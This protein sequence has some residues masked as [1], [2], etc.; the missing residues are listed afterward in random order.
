MPARGFLKNKKSRI[1]I[2]GFFVVCISLKRLKIQS[3]SVSIFLMLTLYSERMS[4]QK[5]YPREEFDDDLLTVL[6]QGKAVGILQGINVLLIAPENLQPHHHVITAT[7][8]A[9]RLNLKHRPEPRGL[10]KLWQGLVD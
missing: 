6:E 10:R 8:V 3:L 2:A 1:H 9:K 4:K 7:E 5:Q